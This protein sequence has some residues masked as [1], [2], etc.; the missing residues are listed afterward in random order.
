M[1]SSSAPSVCFI[2]GTGTISAACL[3]EAQS[4]G[5]E[6]AALNRGVS[7]L[8]PLPDGV[9]VLRADLD[10]DQ[11]VA[12]ALAGRHF[13][14]VADFCSYTPTRLRRNVELLR[15]HI[16]QY[17]F[18]SSASAYQKP[19]ATLPITESTPLRN[20]FWQ[21]SRDK[22]DC[23]DYLNGMWR[24]DGFP[25]TVVRPSHTYDRFRVPMF[26]YWT[27]IVRARAGKPMV[28]QGDGTSLWTLT[29]ASDF[30]YMFAGLIANPAALGQA[31][32]IMGD[33][34][35]T[36]DA[37]AKA[38]ATAAGVPDARIVHVA[39]ETIAAAMPGIRG[40]LLGD[41]AHSVV[42]DCAKVRA[43]RPG[44]AQKVPFWRGARD[45]VATYDQHCEL[46][47]IDPTVDAAL[48]K[49]VAWANAVA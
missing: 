41:K 21:Y 47:M 5:F 43:L 48:D 17:I 36:W 39:S 13:D 19:V 16:G 26:G 34:V 25:M 37:I 35:L 6:V 24:G 8:R 22:I 9:T 20:D 31:Y 7:A 28:V 3:K 12:D 11:G 1:V 4:L 15:G 45:I 40:D 38:L 44:F 46:A 49:L 32:Q 29:H 42:F 23:E 18:I 33:E 30:A 2:G 14:T 27:Q 10:D